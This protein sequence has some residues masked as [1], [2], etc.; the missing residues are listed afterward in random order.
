MLK[1][2]M[3]PAEGA[4]RRLSLSPRPCCPVSTVYLKL[5][6]V[7][8]TKAGRGWCR[9]ALGEVLRDLSGLAYLSPTTSTPA[10]VWAVC[11]RCTGHPSSPGT[12]QLFPIDPTIFVPVASQAGNWWWWS[13]WQHWLHGNLC[14]GAGKAPGSGFPN[15]GTAPS[16]QL[17]GTGFI[18]V[19][20]NARRQL[21]L[22][23]SAGRPLMDL[24]SSS[25]SS[26]HPWLHLTCRSQ[27]PKT[28]MAK[29]P[30]FLSPYAPSLPVIVSKCSQRE[31][32]VPE[33]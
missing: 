3:A 18:C 33:L 26:Y 1:S 2:L 16:S 23:D 31:K 22:G 25:C 10:W 27:A 12:T 13:W 21:G 19:A 6:P 14:F 8:A 9:E 29:T 5:F 17:Q 15:P 32:V 20:S 7:P 11:C 30:P 28:L 4:A 24:G